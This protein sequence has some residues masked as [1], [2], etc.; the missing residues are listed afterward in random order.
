M[1]DIFFIIVFTMARH[2]SLSY[3]IHTLPPFLHKIHFNM[4]YSSH[5][6][7]GP[8]SRLF[9]SGCPTKFLYAYIFS[10][11]CEIYPAIASFWFDPNN[12][13]WTEK[14]QIMELLTV[15][16]VPSSYQ[17]I[18]LRSKY[19]PRCPVIKHSICV[20]SLIWDAKFY[21]YIKQQVNLER[22]WMFNDLCWL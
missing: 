12:I 1:E 6:G 9:S 11:T 18:C 20:L 13:S 14:L 22:S 8:P 10:F 5:I 4:I 21:N 16:F 3:P 19:S 2:R 15:K 7:P 17:L